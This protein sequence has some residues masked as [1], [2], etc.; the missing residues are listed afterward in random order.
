MIWL[1]GAPLALVAAIYLYWQIAYPTHTY[2]FRL[3]VEVD[4]PEGVKS[5]SSVYEVQAKNVPKLLPEM[6]RR[7]WWVRGEAVAIDL[8]G[9][10]T[11][12]ALLKT[13]A[14]FGDMAGLSMNTLHPDF[15][16]ARYDVVGVAKE[17]AA[18][19]YRAHAEVAPADYPM[20]VTFA[21]I[22]NPTS[23]TTVDPGDLAATFGEG[24]SL[25]RI[26]VQIT[27]EP[28]TTGIEKRLG[29]LGEF[30]EPALNPKHGPNDFSISATLKHGAFRQGANK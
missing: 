22:N 24:V 29:W 25:R 17:L 5:G 3:T 16:G 9:G 28:V 2:R 12:F 14:H 26:T 20:L 4:T 1:V 11:L 21:D 7:E 23:V 13:G 30:P 10:Q 15:R 18:G 6:G 8:P 19:Q 27:D